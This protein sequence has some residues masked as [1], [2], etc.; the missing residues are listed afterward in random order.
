MKNLKAEYY[1]N[2][3]NETI[4]ALFNPMGLG[5]VKIHL[6]PTRKQNKYEDCLLIFNGRYFLTLNSTLTILVTIFLRRVN[7]FDGNPVPEEKLEIVMN[8]SLK[9]YKEI[10]PFQ[11][12][13]NPKQQLQ[14]FIDTVISVCKGTFEGISL[15]DFSKK[16][17][18]PINM[19]LLINPLTKGSNWNCNQNCMH[20]YEKD[21]PQINSSELSTLDWIRIIDKLWKEVYVSQITFT[22]PEPTVR[23]DFMELINYSKNFRTTLVTNGLALEKSFCESLYSANLDLLKVT[24]YSSNEHLHNKLVGTNG[25]RKTI[26]GIQNALSAGLNVVVE[27]PI[28]SEE[29]DY[30][31]T[32]SFLRNIGVRNVSLSNSTK[33][34]HTSKN[35]K[36]VSAFESIFKQATTY[37]LDTGM[38][39][40]LDIPG[41]ISSEYLN[42]FNIEVPICGA[43][44]YYMAISPNGDV[45]P[46][47]NWLG[48]EA[49]VGNILTES[50][51]TIWNNPKCIQVRSHTIQ[52]PYA[53]PFYE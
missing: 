2:S 30:I 31:T 19:S 28:I 22:G 49:S 6:I 26:S 21:M 38:K 43:C 14:D 8:G 25:F 1:L 33:Y 45:L 46:C 41:Q 39:L 40:F 44:L 10:F 27:T 42:S 34:S 5:V 3:M 7:F 16:I 53:C 48:N 13:S 4:Y 9:E 11:F 15:T 23:K 20:C 52:V 35:I 37:C 47:K 24:L 17:R 51:D 32:L 12:K 29:Q 36:Y 50:W 18:A